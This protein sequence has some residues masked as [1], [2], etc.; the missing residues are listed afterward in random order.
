MN[1]NEETA[2]Q[3]I[4][5]SAKAVHREKFI[6]VNAYIEE[7]KRKDLK[8]NNLTFHLKTLEKEDKLKTNRRKEIIKISA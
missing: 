7:K 2:C 1:K 8:I 6:F 4:Q 5:D 3:S